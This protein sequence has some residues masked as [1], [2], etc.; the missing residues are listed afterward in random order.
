MC[1]AWSE[2]PNTGF[3]GTCH[4]Q[5][6]R[7]VTYDTIHLL[8]SSKLDSSALSFVFLI[9]IRFHYI[10]NEKHP[11]IIYL[12]FI[13]L[14]PSEI[15]TSCVRSFVIKQCRRFMSRTMLRL[16]LLVNPL[17]TGVSY[18]L[19]HDISLLVP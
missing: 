16:V 5:T 2:I 7:Y 4:N 9:N 18:M 12:A 1:P 10:Y 3:H 11:H 13:K 17:V 14:I 15:I 19:H 8:S 6:S